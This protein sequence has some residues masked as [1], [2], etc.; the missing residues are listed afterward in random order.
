MGT[1]WATGRLYK[2]YF[3]SKPFPLSILSRENKK[4]QTKW[5]PSL[6]RVPLSITCSP[7]VSKTSTVL[8]WALQTQTAFGLTDQ[9]MRIG[10]LLWAKSPPAA[11]V[12]EGGGLSLFSSTGS[13]YRLRSGLSSA[14]GFI[15]QLSE[16]HESTTA[17]V[18]KHSINMSKKPVVA[19]HQS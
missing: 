12:W 5:F 4:V 17:K 7:N 16:T 6:H 18:H 19:P 1:W 15:Q 2:Q 10:P 13:I 8:H 9:P 3:F 14:A 11:E